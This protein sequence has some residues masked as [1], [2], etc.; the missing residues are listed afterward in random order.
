MI[1]IVPKDAVFAE[2]SIFSNIFGFPTLNCA[3][4]WTET[5]L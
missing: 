4:I 5:K 1:L 3:P 2:I